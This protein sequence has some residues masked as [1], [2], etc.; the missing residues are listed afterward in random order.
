MLVNDTMENISH[1]DKRMSD[2]LNIDNK[3]LIVEYDYNQCKFTLYGQNKNLIGGFSCTQLIKYLSTTITP[4]FLS[5]IDI[6]TS[7]AII[8]TY[9]CK[10]VNN[11]GMLTINL[12]NHIES[13]FMG[14]IDMI[15]KLY[16]GLHKFEISQLSFEID[17]MLKRKQEDIRLKKKILGIIKQF[18]YLLLNHSL[19]L[20]VTISDMTKNDITKKELNDSLLKYSVAIVYRLSSFMKDE[21]ENKI[22]EYKNLQN[23]IVRVAN[24]KMEMYK[25]ISALEKSIDNQNI[26]LDNI[27]HKMNKQ[28]GGNELS[29][30]VVSLKSKL[31][32][33]DSSSSDSNATV[34][35]ESNES[36]KLEQSDNSTVSEQ[37]DD[38]QFDDEQSDNDQF[39]DEQSDDEQIGGKNTSDYYFTENDVL[40]RGSTMTKSNVSEIQ[41]LLD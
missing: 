9:I 7:F 8:E 30:T 22:S 17:N 39:D 36:V 34:S 27:L 35:V 21:V 15:I 19:K 6:G 12:K 31:K 41:D 1:N 2:E 13:P 40:D 32:N 4:N 3:S 23:D 25:K 14:N 20:I 26:Q 18:I 5:N 24:I 28:Y 33:D 38:D 16:R 10:I 11:S 37:S 29:S